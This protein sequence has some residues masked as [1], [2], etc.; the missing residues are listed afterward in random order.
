M[1][2]DKIHYKDTKRNNDGSNHYNGSTALEFRPGRPG[3]FI[4]QFVIYIC[5]ITL[6]IHLQ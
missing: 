1:S 6:D 2:E 3:H 4:D 5:E